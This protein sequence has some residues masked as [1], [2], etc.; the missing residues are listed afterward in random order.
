MSFG[1]V[2]YELLI[3]PLQI[4]FEVIFG[5]AYDITDNYGLTIIV[6]SLAMNFLVL[7][8]YK[9]ADAMQEEERDTQAKLAKGVA[10]IKKTFK[11]DERMM[12]LQTY[13]RQ[14]N[15]KPTYV[16]KGA[17]SLLLQIPFFI[18][19]YKFLSELQALQGVDFGLIKDLS[20]PDGL[21]TV[22]GFTVNI[23][24]VLMTVINL[25]SS[26]I[27]S[28]NYPLKTKVQL[29]LTALFFLVFLYKSPSGLVFYWTLNNSFSLLKTIVFKTKD[30]KHTASIL[31]SLGGVAV[32]IL[33]ILNSKKIDESNLPLIFIAAILLQFPLLF[34]ILNKKTQAVG[35]EKSRQKQ[36]K[37]NRKLFIVTCLFMTVLT[38]VV[39]PSNVIKASP[40]EFVSS[41]YYQNPNWYTVSALC[42]ATGAFMIWLQVFY[43]FSSS[44]V[45]VIFEKF[46]VVLCP[47]ALVN[48]MGFSKIL[49]IINSNLSYNTGLIYSTNQNIINLILVVGTI[50]IMLCLAKR[51]GKQITSLMLVCIVAFSGLGIYNTVNINSS[52]KSIK[53][54]DTNESAFHISLSKTKNNVVVIMLDRAMGLYV[55]YIFNEKP[56]LKEQF[57]GFKYYSNVISYGRSTIFGSPALFGG[58]EYT[59]TEINTRNTELL[60]Q[61]QTEALKVMPV[62][63][64]K[65]GFDVTV[66]NPTFA[67]YQYKYDTSIYNDYKNIKAYSVES[68]CADET[69]EKEYINSLRPKFFVHS[70]MLS[71]PTSLQGLLYDNGAYYKQYGIQKAEDSHN[72]VGT[73]NRFNDQFSI[74]QGLSSVTQISDNDKG[75]FLMMTNDTTHE[76]IMLQEPDYTPSEIVDNTEYDKNNSQRFSYNGI[77]V[78]MNSSR[79]YSLYQTNMAAMIQLGNWFDYLKKQGV[80]DNTKII[81]VSDHGYALKMGGT[82]KELIMDEHIGNAYG[83]ASSYFPL[84]MVKDYN[85]NGFTVSDDFMSNADVP[86]I[87]FNGLIDNP[88]NPFTNNPINDKEKTAHN[89]YILASMNLEPGNNIKNTTFTPG[90]WYTVH[91]SIWDKSNWKRVANNKILTNKD[92]KQ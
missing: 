21:L 47:C 29:Y 73:N 61:K 16:L 40:Q 37:S 55:P 87:A 50:C 35:K 22:F 92:V 80:Y 26:A 64:D 75:C 18:A 49:G 66:C 82:C 78:N 17:A 20:K 28:K 90:Y 7:P 79:N 5:I 13:Y 25:I 54:N 69:S 65:N 27:Y 3:Q 84:L 60:S 2:I 63:F 74:L 57:N 45:K 76:P 1:S 58:Y 56:E 30:K 23:L 6:L 11:G 62:L 4:I 77:T 51:F 67:N 14:N 70:L 91:D 52:V 34:F 72:A 86:T 46:M 44:K 8:L 89:Q 33:C 31:L 68:F 24:P 32:G 10:H 38:G 39:I 53:N 81:L 48:Y 88:V 15:Y 9:R 71:V 43:A 19:A 85:S 59:P 12:M 83:D 42:L 41:I 36:F